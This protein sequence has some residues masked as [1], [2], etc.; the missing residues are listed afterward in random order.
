MKNT[1]IFTGL[2]RNPALFERSVSEMADLRGDGVLERILFVTW[3]EYFDEDSELARTLD[4]YDVEVITAPESPL[5]GDGNIWHQMKALDLGLRETPNDHWVLKTR[6]DL[7]ISKRFLRRL[8]TGDVTRVLEPAESGVFERRLWTSHFDVTE[9]FLV[10]DLCFY[11]KA[12]DVAQL[13]N[14]S[15]RYEVLY[16]LGANRPEKRRYVHPYMEEFP[17]V[18]TYYERFLRDGWGDCQSYV[19]RRALIWERAKAPVSG[20]FL[21]LYFKLVNA[22]FHVNV[23]PVT[24]REGELDNLANPVVGDFE[25]TIKQGNLHTGGIVACGRSSYLD[26]LLDRPSESK[27]PQPV[28]DGFERPFNAWRSHEPDADSISEELRELKRFVDTSGGRTNRLLDVLSRRVLTK[29]GAETWTGPVYR[30][31]SE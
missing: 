29:V 11:G 3:R 30:W 17:L 5:A 1:V 9:P 15:S 24:F 22:D 20:S 12:T 28:V 19:N 18:S 27:V 14:Y 6:T 13:V 10:S 21:G 8:F 2:P 23:R 25:A 16:E 4:G 7:H 26:E 31:I